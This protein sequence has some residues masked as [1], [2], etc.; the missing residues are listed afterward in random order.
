MIE[1]VVDFSKLKI[2]ISFKVLNVE[3]KKGKV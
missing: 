3:R 1:S 2:V